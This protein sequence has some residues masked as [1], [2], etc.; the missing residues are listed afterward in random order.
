MAQHARAGSTSPG[1]TRAARRGCGRLCASGQLSDRALSKLSRDG[2]WGSEPPIARPVNNLIIAP[3]WSSLPQRRRLL[4][5]ARTHTHPDR[6]WRCCD[7][8]RCWP[9]A[10]QGG[11]SPAAGGRL[12][13]GRGARRSRAP[14]GARARWTCSCARTGASYS[15]CW[16]RRGSPRRRRAA[17][18]WTST[19]QASRCC[20]WCGCSGASSRRRRARCRSWRRWCASWRMPCRR[21]CPARAPS[22]WRSRAGRW[23]SCSWAS[24]RRATPPSRPGCRCADGW[25][26][27]LR[28]SHLQREDA[29]WA[30]AWPTAPAPPPRPQAVSGCAAQLQASELVMVLRAAGRLGDAA[31][32]PAQPGWWLR[33]QEAC[34]GQLGRMPAEL[35]V[36]V[37][38]EVRWVAA[39][40]LDSAAP[41]CRWC[42]CRQAAC[43][44]R[45]GRGGRR[46]GAR[47][48]AP[49][50]AQVA[51]PQAQRQLAAPVAG[52]AAARP[53][54][55]RQRPG[56][57]AGGAGGGGPR[58]AGAAGGGAWR[59]AVLLVPG[60]GAAA[61]GAERQAAE[62]VPVGAGGAG[63]PPGRGLAAQL[64]CCPV[65]ARLEGGGAAGGCGGERR[66]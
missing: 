29:A 11:S 22:T 14:P 32:H 42:R 49:S 48:L 6:R 39:G 55:A 36:K 35:L 66:S 23:G 52:G 45:Q 34:E 54:G 24:W 38:W 15:S 9:P 65:Q 53:G 46:T 10:P 57:C 50:T 3:A 37:M 4:F 56:A 5:T 1:S 59:L 64:G 21:T 28:R 63:A 47:P 33:W 2:A 60:L 43:C 30:S 12:V 40:W 27:L 61:G 26:R 18:A 20:T 16:R 41:A 17:R 8:A 44:T 51:G 62:L 19:A 58:R 13:P 31:R 7:G 25:R